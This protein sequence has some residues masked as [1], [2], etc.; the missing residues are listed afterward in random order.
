MTKSERLLA[1]LDLL[2]SYR[3]PV[4]GAVLAKELKVSLRTLYRDIA[5]LQAQGATIEGEAGL[6]FVLRPGFHV[7]PLMFSHDELEALVLGSR[8]VA[9]LGEGALSQDARSAMAKIA[10]C[11]PKALAD[12]MQAVALHVPPDTRFIGQ[13]ETTQIV[14]LL[15]KTIRE[16]K[17]LAIT[18]CDAQGKFS[19]RVIWAFGLAFFAQSRIILAHCEER[20]DFRHFRT[21]RILSCNPLQENYPQSR[22]KLLRDWSE[23]MKESCQDFKLEH[24]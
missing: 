17:K 6:G 12:S 20:D 3:Y 21:D 19:K 10:A 4:T 18:Y 2:R 11:L 14:T 22:N 8:L 13:A 23:M 5:S 7:P 1:L 15:R 16:R 9:S 24:F